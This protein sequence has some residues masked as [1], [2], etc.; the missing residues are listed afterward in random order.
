MKRAVLSMLYIRK[1]YFVIIPFFVGALLIAVLAICQLIDNLPRDDHRENLTL[2]EAQS[3]VTF[4]ICI[5]TYLP[6]D[7]DVNPLIIYDSDAADV[8]FERYIRLR[9]FFSDHKEKA[10]EINQRYT[11]HSGLQS[12]YPD[13]AFGGDKVLLLWW[14]SAP[15]SLAGSELD[16]AMSATQFNATSFETDQIVWWLFEINEPLQY[17]STMT[18]WIENQVE[19]RIMSYLSADEIEKVTI[20]MFECSKP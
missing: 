7:V 11:M 10:L 12:S 4:T 19:Y 15:N 13:S 3:L 16:D 20:S 5:P 1:F 17:R 8:D 14:I 18:H 9:Y 2:E 6:Q